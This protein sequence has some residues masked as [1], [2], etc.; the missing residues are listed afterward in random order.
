MSS[1][2]AQAAARAL[3]SIGLEETLRAELTWMR[4]KQRDQLIIKHVT[5]AVKQVVKEAAVHLVCIL[6][7]LT[8]F[9]S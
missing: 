7:C 1:Y 6:P 8:H 3:I 2:P 5:D 9:T 4:H